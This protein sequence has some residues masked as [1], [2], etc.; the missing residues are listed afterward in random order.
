MLSYGRN[1]EIDLVLAAQSVTDLAYRARRQLTEIF[2]FK[3]ADG[4]SQALDAISD[5]GIDPEEVQALPHALT[6]GRVG[7]IY[8]H[9]HTHRQET[10]C[11]AI[12]GARKAS[13]H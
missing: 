3:H 12:N 6:Q 1:F 11:H 9:C 8:R 5:Y 10:V 13:S 2:V 7:Y 4:D